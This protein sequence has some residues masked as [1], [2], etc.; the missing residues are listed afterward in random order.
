MKPLRPAFTIIEIL[1]SVIILSLAIVP[2]L[3]L[4]TDNREQIIY[5]SERNKRALQDSLY[6]DTAIFQQHKETKSAYEL[7]R[8][9]FKIKELKS[10]EILKKN[11]RAIYIPEAIRITPL[12]EQGGPS[13][14][15]NEVMLKDKHSS[16]YYQF[17]LDAFQ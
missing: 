10:R 9:S 6:L 11:S 4:H 14:I 13:A 17:T 3:K 8:D 16:S 1:I 5:I 12:P 2:V 7:L 15:I